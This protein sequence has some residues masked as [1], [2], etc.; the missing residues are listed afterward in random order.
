[1]LQIVF[2]VDAPGAQPT[3]LT[4]VAVWVCRRY[5]GKLQQQ[6]GRKDH[7][8]NNGPADR[9]RHDTAASP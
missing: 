1:M 8:I 6:L 4:H 5:H 9:S 2:D 3:G 7:V